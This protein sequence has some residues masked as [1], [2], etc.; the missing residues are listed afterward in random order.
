LAKPTTSKENDLIVAIGADQAGVGLRDIVRQEL[1]AAGAQVEDLSA[2]AGEL[3]YP[4]VAERVAIAV[5]TNQAQ[6]GVLVCGTGIGMS[7]TANKVDGVRAALCPDPYSARMSREHNDAN[8]LCM[9][10]RTIGP[11]VAT[12]ILKA[13]LSA[14]ASQEERHVR[15]RAKV[16]DLERST[17]TE[18][19]RK[20]TR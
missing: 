18:A 4:D 16:D 5:A 19:A 12:E 20:A 2:P 10:G 1:E 7:I 11:A 17:L 3:D 6:K 14:D 13:W 9:G 8:V 15:R